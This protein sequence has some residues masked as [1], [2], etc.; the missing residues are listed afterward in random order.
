MGKPCGHSRL[1][2]VFSLLF[3]CIRIKR[4]NGMEMPVRLRALQLES[5]IIFVTTEKAHAP[6]F[7]PIRPFSL[8]VKPYSKERLDHLLVDIHR[9]LS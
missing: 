2:V 5:I 8:P 7:Y 6:D 1:M 4:L 3:L 9:A